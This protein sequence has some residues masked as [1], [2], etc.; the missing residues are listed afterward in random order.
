MLQEQR[1]YLALSGAEEHQVESEKDA[2][3]RERHMCGSLKV[4][5]TSW[6]IKEGSYGLCQCQGSEENVG[7]DGLAG[8]KQ[9]SGGGQP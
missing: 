7:V 3:R 9:D 5:W 2:W 1:E 4:N 6:R 8:E